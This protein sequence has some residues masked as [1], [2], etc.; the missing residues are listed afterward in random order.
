MSESC[1]SCSMTIE[2]GPYCEHCT[3]SDG[4]LRDFDEVFER[5]QQ[6][7][8]RHEPGKSKEEVAK[9]TLAFMRTMPAWKDHPGVR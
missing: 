8:R 1:Q 6:W 9:S 4:T 7:T 3:S 5:F 2:S